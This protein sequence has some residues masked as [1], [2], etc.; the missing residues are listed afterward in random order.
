M[1]S[2]TTSTKSEFQAATQCEKRLYLQKHNHE[3]AAPPSDTL[4]RRAEDGALVGKLGRRYYPG[5]ILIDATNGEPLEQTAHAIQ[6]GVE[7]PLP[8]KSHLAGYEGFLIVSPRRGE[9]PRPAGREVVRPSGPSR[10]TRG[11]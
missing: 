11:S 8:P 1:Q 5:G 2:P 7:C 10:G 6:S 4:D 9:R 3:L